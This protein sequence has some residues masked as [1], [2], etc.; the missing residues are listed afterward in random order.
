MKKTFVTVMLIL[1]ANVAIL[2]ASHPLDTNVHTVR[3]ELDGKQLASADDRDIYREY[4][5]NSEE[6]DKHIVRFY[7]I[8]HIVIRNDQHALIRIYDAK[9]QLIE[10]TTDDVDKDVRA[11]NY[12]VTCS[13]R[14]RSSYTFDQP[15]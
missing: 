8:D 4:A 13:S 12:Y 2:A 5:L 1:A 9:W 11:G 6:N 7:D 3:T 10:Q 14:I 15:R